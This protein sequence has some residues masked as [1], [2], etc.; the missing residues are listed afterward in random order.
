MKSG[1]SGVYDPVNN[2]DYYAYLLAMSGKIAEA[3]EVARALK[4]DIEQKNPTLM[5]SYWWTLGDI[6]QAKGDIKTAIDYFEK[7]DKDAPTPSFY[8]RYTLAKIYLQTGR[9]DEAV[10]ELEKA[11]SRYD[12]NR[13]GI[14]AVKAYYLLGLAYEKSGWNKKAI[15]Q[16]EEFLDIW[17]N[18]D[19]GIPE[20]ADAK[21]RLRKLKSRQ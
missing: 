7:A 19:P 21:E 6:E 12:G 2:R 15:A 1:K 14:E 20:V 17:K 16:Y 5:Y 18:A 8:R 3:E 4:K 10:A 13:L 9:L 11:L